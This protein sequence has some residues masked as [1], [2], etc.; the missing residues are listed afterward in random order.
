MRTK[1]KVF[2]AKTAEDL[3]KML[4][5][6]PIEFFATQIFLKDGYDCFAYYKDWKD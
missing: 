4:N 3:A 2:H 6:D 1:I 5:D